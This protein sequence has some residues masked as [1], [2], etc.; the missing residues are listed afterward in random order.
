MFTSNIDPEV[1]RLTAAERLE[2]GE[3]LAP[4]FGLRLTT[5]TSRT[6]SATTPAPRPKP[7][8]TPQSNPKG[9]NPMSIKLKHRDIVNN[10]DNSVTYNSLKLPD[11]FTFKPSTYGINAE[12]LAE[13][14][15]VQ[16]LVE[17]YA[18]DQHNQRRNGVALADY[19][20][21]AYSDIANQPLPHELKRACEKLQDKF[22]NIG[23]PANPLAGV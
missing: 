18:S 6:T 14:T 9:F 16:G 15:K 2:L 10:L 7:A 22:G 3:I 1:F 11:G 23:N 4:I 13:L 19:V 17:E 5:F 12:E 20:R 8:S 21:S